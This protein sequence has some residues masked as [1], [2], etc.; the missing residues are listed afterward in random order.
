MAKELS[1]Y[2]RCP[3]LVVV[4]SDGLHLGILSRGNNVQC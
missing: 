1:S 4:S 3:L 2:V